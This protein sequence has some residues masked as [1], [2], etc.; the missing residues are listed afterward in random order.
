MSNILFFF[1][2]F[3]CQSLEESWIKKQF[4]F[5]INGVYF[6][7]LYLCV[8]INREC[9]QI[10]KGLM[11]IFLSPI[12]VEKKWLQCSYSQFYGICRGRW[13]VFMTEPITL[14]HDFPAKGASTHFVNN[15][16]KMSLGADNRSVTLLWT[17]SISR[18]Y[19]RVLSYPWASHTLT[20]KIA[21]T[22]FKL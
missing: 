10:T 18:L 21:A 11:Q 16:A 1:I 22:T 7:L 15:K 5:E 6:L 9:R 12:F 8:F 14:Y 19:C 4:L 3:L 20:T 13:I 2:L 17:N